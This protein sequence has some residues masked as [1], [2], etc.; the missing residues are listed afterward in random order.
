MVKLQMVTL[1]SV[2]FP[3][4][5]ASAEQWGATTTHRQL[6]LSG[7]VCRG[8]E[9]KSKQKGICFKACFQ[10][11]IGKNT[12]A[13]TSSQLSDAWKMLWHVYFWNTHRDLSSQMM[14]AQPGG[15]W[16]ESLDGQEI[17]SRVKEPDRMLWF[18]HLVRLQSNIGTGAVQWSCVHVSAR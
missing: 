11:E 15:V 8:K 16:F 6:R 5:G 9:A 12:L 13:T 4:D 7:C 10:Y 2:V 1:L 18:D 14:G 17:R 3:R